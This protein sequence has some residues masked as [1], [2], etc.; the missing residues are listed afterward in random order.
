MKDAL[1]KNLKIGD[2]CAY[3]YYD[4][5]VRIGEVRIMGFTEKKVRVMNI[6]PFKVSK[7]AVFLT[8][9]SKL[10]RTLTIYHNKGE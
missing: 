8:E 6:G 2:I 10:A 4:K 1:G 7:K 9:P 5:G 3:A